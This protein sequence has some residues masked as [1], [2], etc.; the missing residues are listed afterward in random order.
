MPATKLLQNRIFLADGGLET[1]IIFNEGIDLPHFSSIT[2][3]ASAEGRTALERYYKR[4]IAIARS[5]GF[6]FILESPTWRSSHDWGDLLGMSRAELKA[7]NAAAISLMIDLRSRHTAPGFPILVSGCVGPR[8]DGYVAG[9]IMRPEAAEAYHDEQI[10]T[11]A[12]AGAELISAIT[13]TN[14]NEAI[15][16][17]RSAARRNLP[18]VISF[19]VETDGRLPDGQRLGEAITDVDTATDAAPAYYMINCAH[20]MHFDHVLVDDAPWTRR[21]MGIRANASSC[22]HAELNEAT[23]LD[24]GDPAD[25]GLRYRTL[26]DRFPHLRVFGGCCGTDH[27]HIAAIANALP[28]EIPS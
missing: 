14:A 26:H 8:G 22:S 9:E 11:M 25:L 1:D 5:N 21:I 16:I 28:R 10:G 23:E 12:A 20:P 27:E 4:Y 18:S 15:G 13:M 19:T 2:L 7:A 17:A 24:R 6:G 3:L